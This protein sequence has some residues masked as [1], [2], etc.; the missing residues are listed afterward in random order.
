MAV[1]SATGATGAADA[2]SLSRTR[3]AEN[4]DTFLTLL[5]TQMKNQ[6]P[7]S[8]LDSNQFTQQ[9]V[10]MTGVEQQL[11]TNDLL[12]QMVSNTASGISAAVSL[13]GKN[14]R[15]VSDTTNLANGEAKWVYSLDRA[16]SDVKI[17]ILNDKGNVV[18]VA[19]PTANGAGEHSFTW[20]G[21]NASGAKQPEGAY[22]IRITAVDSAG[23]AVA[24]TAYVDGFVT[25]V[26]QDSGQTML[27]INGGKVQWDKVTNIALPS[28]GSTGQTGS[29]NT[30]NT[31]DETSPAAAA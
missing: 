8:P 21:K 10:Q 17:E 15:A 14:V 18:D 28:T 9:L 20:D 29:P 25:G 31:D 16:A 13:I 26:M 1:G 7:L 2:S 23:A 24:S 12:K 22:R 30:N 19:A 27:L 5:T 4:F 3:L 6:D 11:M